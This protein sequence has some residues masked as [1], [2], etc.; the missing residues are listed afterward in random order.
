V[1]QGLS[2]AQVQFSFRP[3]PAHGGPLASWRDSVIILGRVE[4]A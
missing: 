3:P 2:V 1:W 4:A